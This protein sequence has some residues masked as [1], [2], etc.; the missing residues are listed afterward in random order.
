MKHAMLWLFFT[1]ATCTT[2]LAQ[3]IYYT[4]DASLTLNGE[5]GGEALK[6]QT[7]QLG[8]K[9]DY[10]TAYMII[11]FPVSSLESGVDSLDLL[12]R[13]STTEV[14]FDGKLSL[15]YIKTEDHPPLKFTSEGWLTIGS[16]KTLITGTGELLHIDDASKIA[17]M[18]GMTAQLNFKDLKLP[19]PLPGLEGGF[20]A[21]IMQAVLK[22]DK[23]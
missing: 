1:A 13:K 8:I 21:V 17:C 6:L 10:E 15:E 12:L 11:R 5:L 2:V 23:N 9:L 16:S 20:E 7:R 18:L 4:L 3:N 19:I 22:K 14:V